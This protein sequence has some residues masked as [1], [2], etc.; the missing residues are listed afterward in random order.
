MENGVEVA[1]HRARRLSRSRSPASGPT[2]ST[3]TTTCST[4]STSPPATTTS[5]AARDLQLPVPVQHAFKNQNTI[6]Q[7]YLGV[8]QNVDDA[9]QNLTQRYTVTR[10]DHRRQSGS[11]SSADGVVPPN[12]QGNATP[13]YNQGDNGE[14]PAKDGVA[15][16]GELD[17]YTRQIDRRPRRGYIAFA[18]QRDD[19]FYADIQAVFD[20]LEASRPQARTP[21]A[22]STSTLMALEIPLSEIGGDQQVVGVYATTSRQQITYPAATEA[23]DAEQLGTVR[24]GGAPGQ[25]ALLRGPGRDRRQGPLQ[26][27]APERGQRCSSR[28][29]R[30]NPSWRRCSTCS[31]S[32]PTSPASRP[33]A[34]TSPAIFIPDL[35]KV[36]LSTGP[37][38]ARG[39]RPDHP[40]NPD[41]AGFSRLEHLR[42]RRARSASPAQATAM[43][44]RRLAERP[45]LRR[46]RA[47]H[48]GDARSSATCA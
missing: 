44:A 31:S 11:G 33:A 25:P 29:T 48:R 37:R 14:N 34:P 24:P 40:T 26:P 35:I 2:S 22:A 28:S 6:L 18:G 3:S 20:L 30:E 46:R 12:N 27:D 45:A 17:R 32:S 47:R 41:D 1:R 42:R 23:S 43:R 39:R 19:G 5:Q 7:S 15:T 8:I 21:R 4:R 36:D 9:A 38:A 16:A 10:V 13:F